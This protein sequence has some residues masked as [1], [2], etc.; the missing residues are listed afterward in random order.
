MNF[1]KMVYQTR[2]IVDL[3][4]ISSISDEY[5][6]QQKEIIEFEKKSRF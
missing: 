4:L 6:T 3:V 5:R 1:R 2:E